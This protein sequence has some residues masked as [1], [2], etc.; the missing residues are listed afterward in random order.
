[1]A[2]PTEIVIVGGSF[3]GRRQARRLGTGDAEIT[4]TNPENY[5]LY[6]PLLPG[7]AS[8]LVESR[9]VVVACAECCASPACAWARSPRSTWT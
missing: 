9:H 1:M 8:G 2:G 7:A 5:M 3:G 6:T 4:V